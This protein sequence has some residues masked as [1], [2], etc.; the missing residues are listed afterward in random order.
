MRQED[1]GGPP[2]LPE[3]LR[4]IRQA[5]EPVRLKAAKADQL[6]TVQGQLQ[7]RN[8][9][10]EEALRRLRSTQ[11]Q[12]VSQQKL[13]ELGEITALAAHEI[14]NPLQFVFNFT[15]SSGELLDQL[16]QVMPQD[17][18]PMDEE[19]LSLYNE[20]A[21]QLRE[22]MEY[23][24]KHGSRVNLVVQRMMEAGRESQ[25][26]F[27][28]RDVN[29][30]LKRCMQAARRKNENS[31]PEL[32][33]EENL[34]PAMGEVR[35]IPSALGQAITNVIDN[36]IHSVCERMTS[37]D[38]YQ[39]AIMLETRMR[40]QN[41]EMRVWDNGN[42]MRPEVLDRATTP[43]FT[44]KLA[45]QGAG[46]GLSVANDIVRE[47]RGTLTLESDPRNYTVAT[48]SIPTGRDVPQDPEFM[49]E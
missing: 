34:D 4:G 36:A 38:G 46:L 7:Q 45:N 24:T 17:G 35:M 29:A 48:I 12:M 27:E 47:H 25:Q 2:G 32:E 28:E 3:E 44:T 23:I 31:H 33:V 5:M 9:Q 18:G 37:E 16:L 14:R 1:R 6:D 49:W 40:G 19:R 41:A 42:G 21:D 22:N 8:D 13:L 10:L 26:E 20:I 11:D 43:F 39:P 15:E 30:L